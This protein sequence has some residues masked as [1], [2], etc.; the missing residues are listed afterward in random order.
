M[1]RTISASH[2]STQWWSWVVLPG[3]LC[4]GLLLFLA[5]CGSETNVGRGPRLNPILDKEVQ[6]GE[7]LIFLVTVAEGTGTAP[8]SFLIN[9]DRPANTEWV[10][11]SDT[12][13]RFAWTPEVKDAQGE[14]SDYLFQFTVKDAD[15]LSD[16]QEVKVRVVPQ[17]GP[18]FLNEPGYVLNLAE[19][20]F[21]EFTVR[22]KDDA[23]S[24]IDLALV[25]A[26]D[27]AYLEQSGKKEAYFFWRPTAEQI[28][29]KRFWYIRLKATGFAPAEKATDPELQLYS[30]DHDIPLV[31][32]HGD[33]QACPGSPPSLAHLVPGDMHPEEVE[34]SSGIVLSA[35]ASDAE[36]RVDRLH[37]FWSRDPNA[38]FS[39]LAMQAGSAEGSYEV[40]LPPF[41]AGSGT[42]VFYY[43][44]AWDDDDSQ[45]S[46]CDHKTRYPKEGMFALAAYDWGF[47][48]E[49][50]QDATEGSGSATLEPGISAGLRLC[51]GDTDT[52]LLPPA[53]GT[54]T[55]SIRTGDEDSAT[56]LQ[57]FQPDSTPATQ[58]IYGE[59]ALAAALGETPT[60]LAAVVE[61]QSSQ[62]ITYSLNLNLASS[63]CQPDQLESNDTLS[64]ASPVL[65]GKI[66]EL[67]LCVND[68]DLFK[69]EVP[70]ATTL[71]ARVLHDASNGDLDLFLLGPDGQ[72]VLRTAETQSDTEVI[73][74]TTG[75][76]MTFYLAVLGYDGATNTYNLELEYNE[77]SDQCVDDTFAP[78][79]VQS[80]AV[81][82]P[83]LVFDGLVSCPGTEDWFAIGL[84]GN[85]TLSIAAK[86]LTNGL[87]ISVLNA[88][89]SLLCQSPVGTPEAS[90]TCYPSLPGDYLFKVGHEG[91]NLISYSLDVW[92]PPP[93]G[94]CA[95]DRFEPNSGVSEAWTISDSV[96]TSLTLCAGDED[97]FS[98]EL[99]PQQVLTVLALPLFE[100]AVPELELRDAAGTHVLAV[101]AAG[102][103]TPYF[104]YLVPTGGTY[105]LRLASDQDLAYSLLLW[106]E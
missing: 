31:L 85:E 42:L 25:D 16:S 67:T 47:Q 97:W 39:A 80:Q 69:L 12:S 105:T 68:V 57:L 15:G 72:Q 98:L 41:S 92:A 32:V 30:L 50:L 29:Q 102:E 100:G 74:F 91:D 96:V 43:F 65:P 49:C 4:L 53:T 76:A 89:G 62:A 51:P 19:S 104:E 27:G 20:A 66:S 33:G 54:V 45:G 55:L 35:T 75:E 26:P 44:E 1:Q 86:G 6:V 94:Q 77:A 5:G 58:A 34:M 40:N 48:G 93:Q 82:V 99:H 81:M 103:D 24:R 87:Q 36:S 9:K 8:Y 46:A 71:D 61:N 73:Q 90:V 60:Q 83:P 88:D 56:S 7:R 95:D 28:A 37:L 84:N 3:A 78:N 106:L 14:G 13:A 70:G 52:F 10:Q 59:G 21:L 101:A 22:V 63:N 64:T 38:T 11:V 23:A 17:S 79:G 18:Q 2:F